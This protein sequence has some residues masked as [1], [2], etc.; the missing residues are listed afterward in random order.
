[1]IF[2]SVGAW[3]MGVLLGVSWC[4]YFSQKHIFSYNRSIS[5]RI[6]QLPMFYISGNFCIFPEIFPFFSL[7]MGELF[8]HFE[9]KGKI[10]G[11]ISQFFPVHGKLLSWSHHFS[12]KSLHWTI[13]LAKIEASAQSRFPPC[14]NSHEKTNFY[15]RDSAEVL[16]CEFTSFQLS[17]SNRCKHWYCF[18]TLRIQA[19][20][21][22]QANNHGKMLYVSQNL[23]IFFLQNGW[24]IRPFW[25]KNGKIFSHNF[26]QC[27]YTGK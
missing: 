8:A 6:S 13:S 17:Y 10:S 4:I 7:K 5:S 2:V 23:P 22:T 1:M 25:E 18:N 21:A 27:G 9:K 20:V 12:Q 26:S 24:I 16:P 11:K 3:S 15:Y 14:N 19:G